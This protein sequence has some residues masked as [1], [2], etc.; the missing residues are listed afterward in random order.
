MVSAAKAQQ[1]RDKH[2]SAHLL[3][4]VRARFW[5]GSPYW[6]DWEKDLTEFTKIIEEIPTDVRKCDE[7]TIELCVMYKGNEKARKL[8]ERRKKR[9]LQRNA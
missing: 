4:R 1:L 3:Y 7:P 6:V 9:E 2:Y 5:S 8:Y